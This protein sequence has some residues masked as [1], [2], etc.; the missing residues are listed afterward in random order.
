MTATYDGYAYGTLANTDDGVT[1]SL[2]GNLSLT[3]SLT[4]TS[5]AISGSIDNIVNADDETLGGSLTLSGGSFDRDGDPQT[6]ST[7]RA[8]FSGLLTDG[9]QSL[10]VGGQL[11]GD[12][13]AN[14]HA[15][16]GGQLLGSVIVSGF[17]QDINGG[18]IAER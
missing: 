2:L 10:D 7:L 9:A 16:V 13:L 14:N 3:V 18:F 1:D 12:F 5:A 17:D 15:A 8:T 4:A 6:D 11:Q